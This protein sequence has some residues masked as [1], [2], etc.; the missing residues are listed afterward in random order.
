M[1]EWLAAYEGTSQSVVVILTYPQV[2]VGYLL[3]KQDRNKNVSKK[4]TT[5]LSIYIH[6]WSKEINEK[7]KR[8]YCTH[9]DI[10]QVVNEDDEKAMAMFMS[11]N[12]PARRTLADIIQEKLTEKQ[13]EIQ[14]QM[15]GKK[16]ISYNQI[17]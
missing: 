8:L 6:T 1:V 7:H 11:K 3:R 13:T 15:S 14:S 12:P 17:A 9:F 5:V 2:F 4:F 10:L 16:H